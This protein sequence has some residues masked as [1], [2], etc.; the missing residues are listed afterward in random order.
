M[1]SQFENIEDSARKNYSLIQV[2]LVETFFESHEPT[3]EQFE[4]WIKDYAEKFSQIINAHPEY[5]ALY[6]EDQKEGIEKISD[7]L[8]VEVNKEKEVTA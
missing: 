3:N 4:K 2:H 7:E 8:Y 5:L 6:A 1:K